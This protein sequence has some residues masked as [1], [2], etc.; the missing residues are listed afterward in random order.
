MRG[1]T[2]NPKVKHIKLPSVRNQH[3][4]AEIYIR[5]FGWSLSK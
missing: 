1:R 5:L 2:K 4:W 3:A